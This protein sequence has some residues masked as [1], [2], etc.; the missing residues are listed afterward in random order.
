MILFFILTIYLIY[1][2]INVLLR[3]KKAYDENMKFFEQFKSGMLDEENTKKLS[4]LLLSVVIFIVW[5]VMGMF[6]VHNI[7]FVI[8]LGFQWILIGALNKKF[9]DN[10]NVK[11]WI[12]RGHAIVA[13]IYYT[14][15][16]IYLY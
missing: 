3:A 7:L 11:P 10:R 5:G 16:L 14:Y 2:E 15:L 12:Y 8:F 4:I 9:K 6:I 13:L 1:Y